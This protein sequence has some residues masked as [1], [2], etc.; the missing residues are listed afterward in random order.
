[1]IWP[2]SAESGIKHQPTRPII[3]RYIK[4]E[5]GGYSGRTLL[6]ISDCDT[7]K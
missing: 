6:I 3:F 4:V 7:V 2:V 5:N 1:M